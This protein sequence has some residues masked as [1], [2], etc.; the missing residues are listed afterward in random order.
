V[1]R[2]LRTFADE[3]SATL[4]RVLAYLGGIAL[5]AVVVTK[6]VTP[7]IEVAAGEPAPAPDWSNVE[8]PHQAFAI[9]VVDP[10]E[11][12]PRYLIRRHVLGGGRKDIIGWGDA[13]S[14]SAAGMAEIY[15]PGSELEGF[16]DAP[17]EIAA[18]TADLGPIG[19]VTQLG[20]MDT[21][22]GPLSLVE[23]AAKTAGMPRNCLGFVRIFDEP[24]LQ[25]AGWYCNGGREIVDRGLLA[26]ALD[27]LT[28]VSAGSD[29]KTAELFARAEVKRTF[30]GKKSPILAATPRRPDWIDAPADPKLRGHMAG[31]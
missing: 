1:H 2:D 18:R 12:A 17:T 19:P 3:V 25:I 4:A 11:P 30:C 10:E 6:L 26:C 21:K 24:R 7:P 31:R 8:R 13:A 29:P 9:A 23:F 5:I 16:A 14:L 27:R 28:L 22:F 20:T 15:R